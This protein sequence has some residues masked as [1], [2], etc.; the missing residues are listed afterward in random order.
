MGS[1]LDT[2]LWPVARARWQEGPRRWSEQTPYLHSHL[3]RW[4]Y[5]AKLRLLVCKPGVMSGLIKLLKL[6]QCVW[7]SS[8]APGVHWGVQKLQSTCRRGTGLA[9]PWET[10]RRLSA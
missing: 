8:Q 4:V 3:G 1:E 5:H 9:W 10:R 6:R 2:S 7:W